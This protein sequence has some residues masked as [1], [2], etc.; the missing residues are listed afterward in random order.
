M[1]IAK[2]QTLHILETDYLTGSVALVLTTLFCLISSVIGVDF[3][4]SLLDGISLFGDDGHDDT[5]PVL[6]P[7]SD[8]VNAD[9]EATK[10]MLQCGKDGSQTTTCAGRPN[11]FYCDPKTGKGSVAVSNLACQILC[12]CKKVNVDVESR[13]ELNEPTLEPTV[14][15]KRNP[16]SPSSLKEPKD[17]STELVARQS[18]ADLPECATREY[19]P[20]ML[21][22]NCPQDD[23][24]RC[25]CSSDTFI[26]DQCKITRSDCPPE[27]AKG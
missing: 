2:N 6:G 4:S 19:I 8:T 10:W 13:G 15:D 21:A 9:T 3:D 16:I 25:V 5:I 12:I 24:L 22:L 11:F 14:L 18:V 23:Y 27:T 7:K 20:A 26:Q 17:S 1:C